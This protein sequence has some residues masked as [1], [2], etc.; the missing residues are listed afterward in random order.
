MPAAYTLRVSTWL[1]L[2]R[3]EVFQFFTDAFNLEKITP[4]FLHFSVLTPAPIPMRLGTLIDYR[5]G[6]H[7]VPMTWKTEIAAWEPPSRFID[8]QLRGPYRQWIHLHEFTDLDGGTLMRDQVDYVVP[9]PAVLGVLLNR[10]IVERDVRTIFSYRQRAIET[11]LGVE[12]R[13]QH[14]PIT[15]EPTL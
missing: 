8:R 9:G 1:P 15:I 2:P 3:T 12:G 6:L 7:G 10:L 4:A 13:A 5:I 14:G 11:A